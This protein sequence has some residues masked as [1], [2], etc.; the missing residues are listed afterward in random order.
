[1]RTI[2]IIPSL[3]TEYI[4][5]VP[6]FV[7]FSLRKLS[8]SLPCSI[9]I[10]FDS[11]RFLLLCEKFVLNFNEILSE[12]LV[13]KLSYY[14]LHGLLGNETSMLFVSN[15][16]ISISFISLRD[17]FL[18]LSTNMIK[19]LLRLQTFSNLISRENQRIVFVFSFVFVRHY[20]KQM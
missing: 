6:C 2:R 3:Y 1:M 16:A 8:V 5:S 19:N 15:I 7:S 12:E 4:M 14:V 18:Y 17:K 11:H 9:G 20:L 10:D 13:R